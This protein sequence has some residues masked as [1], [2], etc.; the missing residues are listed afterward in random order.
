MPRKK[1]LQSRN[2]SALD[3]SMIRKCGLFLPVVLSFF[4]SSCVTVQ[5]HTGLTA[6]SQFSADG[7]CSAVWIPF[8]FKDSLEDIALISK[9][10]PY[11]DNQE[12]FMRNALEVLLQGPDEEDTKRGLVSLVRKARVLDVKI[13]RGIVIVNL[14]K[15]FAPA[16]GSTAIWH[17]RMA[18]HELLRQFAGVRE[19]KIQI[20]GVS[21]E[22]V[23]QP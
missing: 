5:N 14:S 10:I 13:K 17:A 21:E 7:S 9:C 2:F 22:E 6:G 12:I 4:L 23:L 19:V 11:S 3:D 16:G 8:R 20:E 18:V 1:R 15:E